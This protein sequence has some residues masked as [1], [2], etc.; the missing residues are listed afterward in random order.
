M[1]TI[2]HVLLQGR[3]GKTPEIRTAGETP[4]CNLWLATN[5]GYKEKEKTNWHDITVWGKSAESAAKMLTKGDM[6]IIEGI[7]ESRDYEKDGAKV[8]KVGIKANS[9]KFGPGNKKETTSESTVEIP[10]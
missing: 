6:V 10:F 7:I 4:V 2:N 3:L 9:W 1:S 5:D 8:R